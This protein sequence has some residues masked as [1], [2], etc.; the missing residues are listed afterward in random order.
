MAAPRL[1]FANQLRGA[2][3]LAV[4]LVHYTVVVQVLRVDV[5]WVVAAPPP[6]SGAWW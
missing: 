3:A 5:S 2:A 4:V 1:V 6:G